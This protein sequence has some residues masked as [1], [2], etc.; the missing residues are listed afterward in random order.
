MTFCYSHRSA[1]LRKVSSCSWWEQIQTQDQT[2][3]RDLETLG[4]SALNGMSSSNLSS[5]GPGNPVED[6]AERRKEP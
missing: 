1:I 5:Q 6:E 2:R 3:C 4:Q